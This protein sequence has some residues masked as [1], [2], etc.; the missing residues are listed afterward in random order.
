MYQEFDE[1]GPP[2][3]MEETKDGKVHLRFSVI[4]MFARLYGPS[5]WVSGS[6]V[7]IR[8]D[9]SLH[10]RLTGY[11]YGAI[12]LGYDINFTKTYSNASA[13][14]WLSLI[15][16]EEVHVN[17]FISRFGFSFANEEEYS[18]AVGAWIVNYGL[19]ASGTWLDN[20][21]KSKDNLHDLIPIEAEAIVYEKKFERFF[22]GEY[23]ERIRKI[24]GR[25]VKI[26][27]NR[28][29]NLLEAMD[30][31]MNKHNNA[32]DDREKI[33]QKERYNANFNSLMKLIDDFNER[34]RMNK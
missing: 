33:K 34:D 19:E 15:A 32:G 29:L 27:D 23:F 12:T 4:A 30:D 14:S 3:I 28:I 7:N 25:E 31:A 22:E 13:T 21:G 24:N 11:N 10:D 16:H 5:F 8:I 26:K 17:Q 18:K 2:Y 20:I 1:I 9:Q 6:K